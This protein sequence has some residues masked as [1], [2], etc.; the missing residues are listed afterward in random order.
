MHA[1]V[2]GCH[3]SHSTINDNSGASDT[4][5]GGGHKTGLNG[6]GLNKRSVSE[7]DADTTREVISDLP[8]WPVPPEELHTC[9]IKQRPC[10][11]TH[12][13]WFVLD[14]KRLRPGLYFH[15][16]SGKD[17]SHPIDTLVCSPI[18]VDALTCDEK[19]DSW[20]MLLRFR[21]PDGHWR[22]WAMPSRLLRGNGEELRGMLLEKGVRISPQGNRLIL[23]WLAG[24]APQKRVIAA[25]RTGWYQQ[26]GE[27][28][29]FVFPHNVIGSDKI[30]FQ[31]EHSGNHDFKSGGSLQ[32]WQMQVAALCVGNPVLQFAM[33]AAFAGPLLKRV[34]QD[35]GGLGIHLVG[36]SSKGKTTA[37]HVA[38]SVWGPPSFVKSWRATGNG[39]ESVA[40]TLNDTLLVLDEISECDPYE[41]GAIVYALGNGVGKQRANRYG[42]SRETSRWRL[43]WLSSGERTLSSHMREANQQVKAG[44]QVRLLDIPATDRTYGVF[45]NLHGHISGGTFA[46]SLSQAYQQ[47]YGHAGMQFIERLIADGQDLQ[48]LYTQILNLREFA[49]SDSLIGRAAKAFALIGMAGELAIIYG[50]VPWRAGSALESASMIYQSWKAFRGTGNTEDQQILKAVQEF[51]ERYGE[52]RFSPLKSE[53][54]SSLPPNDR[55]GYWKDGVNGRVYCFFPTAVERIVPGFEKSRIALTLEQ[56]GWLYDRDKDKRTKKMMLPDGKLMGLYV[57]QPREPEEAQQVKSEVI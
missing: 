31:S 36:D 18:Y 27:P 49:A 19:Q 34:K 7:L 24:V 28:L 52:A 42:T 22:E 50:I 6:A 32:D 26:D 45:D 35:G 48:D 5:G 57:V 9:T 21:N 23:E 55:A 16:C 30:Y 37:L 12:D 43:M 20:G 47:H 44:Q 13:A 54:R 3:M 41:I 14:S 46:D 17:E 53:L 2:G 4:T 15:T 33:S 38:A 40:S 8:L 56:A 39:L 29:V 10:F 51:I 25:S 1:D 11:E